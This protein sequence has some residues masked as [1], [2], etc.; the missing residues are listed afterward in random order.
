MLSQSFPSTDPYVKITHPHLSTLVAQFILDQSLS[1]LPHFNRREQLMK[2]LS[3]HFAMLNAAPEAVQV[4]PDA[5][6]VWIQELYS[7]AYALQVVAR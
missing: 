2:D 3:L 6:I 5:L 1:S 4:N 7:R